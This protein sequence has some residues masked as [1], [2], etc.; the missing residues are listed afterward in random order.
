M[1]LGVVCSRK[2]LIGPKW[3]E[4]RGRG[5]VLH[6]G[7]PRGRVGLAYTMYRRLVGLAYEMEE[8]REGLAYAMEERRG[9]G[10]CVRNGGVTGGGPC[11]RHGGETGG[12]LR[13][14]WE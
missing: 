11:V 1:S 12:T 7:L 13:T 9:G 2:G 8:R 6:T 3:I 10:P 4:V 14:K 5:G